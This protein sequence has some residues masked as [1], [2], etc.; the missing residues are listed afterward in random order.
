VFEATHVVPG[1]GVQAWAEPDPSQPAVTEL[2]DG[3]E[4]RV[5]EERGQWARVEGS[6]GWTGWVD[7][8]RLVARGAPDA[9]GAG[10]SPPPPP[11][12]FVAT[13]VVPQGGMPAWDVPDGSTPSSATLQSGT[14]LRVEERQG[15]WAR[16]EGS[17][18]WTGWVDAG[19]LVQV[20]ATGAPVFAG[21]GAVPTPPQRCP[22]CGGDWGPEPWVCQLCGQVNG[23]ATGLRLSS[24]GKRFGGVLLDVVLSVLTLGIGWLIWAFAIFGRGQTPAKQILGMRV[25]RVPQQQAASWGVM[26]VREIVAKTLIG[27]LVPALVGIVLLFW[28]L[29]DKRRQQ[30]WDKVVDTVVI[31]DPLNALQP[32]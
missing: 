20:G 8:G 2:A 18:G 17:N 13:H 28:L 14:Q 11:S 25:V 9:I 12:G 29:W 16:V 23:L 24:A 10:T 6:N 31:D 22:S 26:F 4:L 21:M 7:A 15:G 30:L 32:A 3:V 5:L 19:R 1:G 27:F